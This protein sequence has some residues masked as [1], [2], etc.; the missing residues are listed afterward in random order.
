ML[1]AR[2]QREK[3]MSGSNDV[4]PNTVMHMKAFMGSSRTSTQLGQVFVACSCHFETRETLCS[5]FYYKP[6]KN[7]LDLLSHTLSKNRKLEFL[8]MSLQEQKC[9]IEN[10]YTYGLNFFYRY[11]LLGNSLSVS[12][13]ASLL[14]YL[15]S[16][17][18]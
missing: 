3:Y 6:I 11:A 8:S 14:S 17:P 15:F 9:F 18:L 7:L 4:K 13:V 12:V 16:E 10:Q 5:G 1:F 2:C